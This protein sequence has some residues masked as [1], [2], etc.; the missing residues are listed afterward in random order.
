MT[1]LALTDAQWSAPCVALGSDVLCVG[2][3]IALAGYTRTVQI[4]E[5]PWLHAALTGALGRG[6]DRRPGVRVAD[7]SLLPWA[8]PSGWAAAW[9]SE[10]DAAAVASTV[11]PARVGRVDVQL[12]LGARTRVHVPPADAPG[13]HLV[14]LTL[15]TPM[16]ISATQ[17]DGAKRSRA[18]AT[19]ETMTS[20][21]WS[22]ARKLRV[23]PEA[24]ACS[25][26][27]DRTHVEHVGYLGK[28]GRLS[29]LVG[30]VDV[31]CNAPAR[32]LI[33]CASRGLGLGARTAFGCGRVVGVTV[34]R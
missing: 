5:L 14:R 19:S 26:L 24:V 16:V 6:H 30:T 15:H 2:T 20:A 10:A 27:D 28:M 21:V 11:R 13:V 1:A 25:V 9:W 29:G 17:R 31:A 33:E 23:Q 34:S 18:S 12:A 32:W 7:W 22:I 8:C 4:H 3:P